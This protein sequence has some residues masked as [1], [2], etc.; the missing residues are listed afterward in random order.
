MAKENN[1]H[2]LIHQGQ[3]ESTEEGAVVQVN[4]LKCVT[5]LLVCDSPSVFYYRPYFLHLLG[6]SRLGM[7]FA[8]E[9]G[10][11]I[12]A[13]PVNTKT[14]NKRK[15]MSEEIFE[16]EEI[17]VK[18]PRRVNVSKSMET[19]GTERLNILIYFQMPILPDDS[20][21]DE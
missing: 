14:T 4:V 9:P 3:E 19:I 7:L 21:Q 13:L 5:N 15:Q 8:K 12:P 1:E 16:D 10:D 6:R 18:K 17:L 2:G 11:Y 20:E